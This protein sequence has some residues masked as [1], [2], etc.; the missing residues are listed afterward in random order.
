L[1]IGVAYSLLNIN[2]DVD[3]ILKNVEDDFDQKIF[4]DSITFVKD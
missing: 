3:E 4:N 2:E 1:F